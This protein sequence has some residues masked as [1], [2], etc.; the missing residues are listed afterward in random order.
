MPRA[1][2]SA[3]VSGRRAVATTMKPASCRAIADARPMPVEHPVTSA[4]P[5]V[6]SGHEVLLLEPAAL[7]AVMGAAGRASIAHTA[8][9]ELS[10]S[11]AVESATRMPA[12]SS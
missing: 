12:R 3:R 6:A 5:R 9:P 10:I 2:S 11:A 4:A 7:A 8:S 1:A